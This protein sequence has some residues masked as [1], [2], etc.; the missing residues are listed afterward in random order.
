MCACVRVCAS[1]CECA[2]DSARVCEF[3]RVCVCLSRLPPPPPTPPL[4][5]ISVQECTCPE[6]TNESKI[7]NG[8]AESGS[9]KRKAVQGKKLPS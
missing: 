4:P 5:G 8:T 7:T 9:L 6:R 2:R 3:V 1:V